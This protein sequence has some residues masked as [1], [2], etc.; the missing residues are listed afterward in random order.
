VPKLNLI[1]RAFDAAELQML[2][3]IM[4]RGE[5]Y[6][7]KEGYILAEPF[8]ELK[9]AIQRASIYANGQARVA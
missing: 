5:R 4:E 1:I 7:E 9:E 3:D 8:Q 6:A 2:S